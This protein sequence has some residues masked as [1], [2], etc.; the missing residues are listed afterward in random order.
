M[1]LENVKTVKIDTAAEHQTIESF[2]ASGA[3]WSQYVGDWTDLESDGMEVREY[4]AQLL[5]DKE[6]GIGLTAYRYN[7][8]GGS[9]GSSK[10]NI[11]DPWRRAYS[12]EVEPGVY[13]WGR[14]AAAVWFMRRAAELGVIEITMFVNS[15]L[16][17]LTVSGMAHATPSQ[18]IFQ[19]FRGRITKLLLTMCL[20]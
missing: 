17:R 15:P 5:F 19:T 7:I 18:R 1:K 11:S 13:D 3:W 8:G 4:I 20:M 16:E 6:K 14:D 10:S 12:F 9:R 2:G